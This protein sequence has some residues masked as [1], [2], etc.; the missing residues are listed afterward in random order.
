MSFYQV[1]HRVI[2]KLCYRYSSTKTFPGSF[3]FFLIIFILNSV[4]RY[5]MSGLGVQVGCCFDIC[6]EKVYIY[7]YTGARG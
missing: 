7:I 3:F 1:T 2:S 4:R 5:L 6:G